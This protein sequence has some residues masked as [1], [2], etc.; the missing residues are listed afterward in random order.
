MRCLIILAVAVFSLP[1]TAAEVQRFELGQLVMEDIPEVPDSIR[2]KLSRY[3]ETR[4]ASLA[5]FTRTGELLIKTRFGNTNQF[6]LVSQAMGA[7]KQISFYDEPVSGG[8]VAPGKV[9][10]GFLFMR[11]SGWNEQS[12]LYYFDFETGETRLLSDGESRNGT[13]KWS[14]DGRRFAYFSTRRN[15][16]SSDIYIGTPQ[17]PETSQIVLEVHGAWWPADWSPDDKRLLLWNYISI[18]KSRLFVYD[19]ENG[20]LVQVNPT[21]EPVGYWG[22]LFSPNGEGVYFSADH[23]SEFAQLQYYDLETGASRIITGNIPW[24]VE[25]FAIADNG[26]WLAYVSNENGIDHVTLYNMRKQRQVTQLRL[27]KGRVGSMDFSLNSRQ[28]A[29]TLNTPRSPGDVYVYDVGRNKLVQWTESEIGGLNANK[30]VSPIF[31]EYDTFDTQDSKPRKIPA[32][33][34]QPASSK[35]PLPVV[36][37][38]HGGPES[39]YTPGFSSLFQYIVNEIGAAVIAPNV[40]GSSGYGKS[41]LKLDNGYGREDSVKDIGALLD[42]I[43]RQP[44]LDENRVVVYGGS[45]GGYM[46]LASMVHFDSRLRGGVDVVG[47][48]NFVT[49]LENTRAYRRDLRREE[50]GDERIPE[51]RAFLESISP[52]N[53]AAKIT[54]PLLVIQGLNDP[55]VPASESEQMVATIRENG[56]KVPYLLARDEG[57]GFRKK[58]NRDYYYSVAAHFLQRVFETP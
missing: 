50:Y 26:R 30:F 32:F 14:N 18:T 27:P 52:A 22:A 3:L 19:L 43:A 57:H 12:Q 33:I 38:I 7:R 35:T 21:D 5:D 39:Q 17:G 9:Y 20:E 42:W 11:D 28:L 54:K 16:V 49:F 24:D 1:V 15:G 36:V 45:Y 34:Y 51:M 29:L 55:R 56:G 41:Y 58:A 4:S 13:P 46:V 10:N 8:S 6:H 53:H 40:R 25:N 44:A 31:F 2:A 47:I 48:S 37:Y 23:E